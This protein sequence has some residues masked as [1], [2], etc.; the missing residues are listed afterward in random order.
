VSRAGH[1][2]QGSRNGPPTAQ[3]PPAR[4][5]L[6]EEP[7]HR[8]ERVAARTAA[9]E[10]DAARRAAASPPGARFSARSSRSLRRQANKK[11]AVEAHRRILAARLE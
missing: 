9:T 1:A 3:R 4:P 5:Y 11:G 6:C 8:F 7:R 10:R 2:R